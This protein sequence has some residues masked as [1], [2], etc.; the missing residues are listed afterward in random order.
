[1]D[2]ERFFSKVNFDGPNGCW[3][4]E[5]GKD[6]DGYGLFKPAPKITHRAHRVSYEFFHG[7]IP[8]GMNVLHSCDNPSCVNPDHL[9]LGTHRENMEDMCHKGRQNT[10]LTA[11]DVCEIRRLH[12]VD[13]V[14]QKDIALAYKIVPSQVSKIVRRRNWAHVT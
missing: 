12:L 4:W 9:L 8:S 14:P 10:I 5:A 3:I 1:M 13:K 6:G 7:P 11:N 2:Q